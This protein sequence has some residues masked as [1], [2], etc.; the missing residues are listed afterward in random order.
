MSTASQLTLQLQAWRLW[1]G[2]STTQSG[3]DSLIIFAEKLSAYSYCSSSRHSQWLIQRKT[4]EAAW[5][6]PSP[7]IPL[8]TNIRTSQLS[9]HWHIHITRTWW[10]AATALVLVTCAWEQRWQS[11]T[12]QTRQQYTYREQNLTKASSPTLAGLY[13]FVFSFRTSQLHLRM[14]ISSANTQPPFLP[15][16]ELAHTYKVEQGCTTF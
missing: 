10:N 5:Q 6:L 13:T 1:R 7:I 16:T 12:C 15:A 9:F 4:N 11:G 3:A 14:V 2:L 8:V